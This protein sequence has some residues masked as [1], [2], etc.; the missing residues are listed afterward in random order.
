[1]VIWDRDL[2]AVP[3]VARPQL[4]LKDAG[5][6]RAES[7]RKREKTSNILIFPGAVPGTLSRQHRGESANT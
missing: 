4:A 3:P 6:A 5:A 7:E 2:S 1:M